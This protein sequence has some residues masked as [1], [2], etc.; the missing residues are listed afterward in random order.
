GAINGRGTAASPPGMECYDDGVLG[1][2]LRARVDRAAGAEM[3]GSHS[4]NV[5]RAETELCGAQPA[6]R[7]LG[8]LS[9]KPGSEAGSAGECVHGTKH[10][11]GRGIVGGDE[12]G[13]GLCPDESE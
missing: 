8:A 2:A 5:P 12:G 11:H 9:Q 13:W 4:S 7:L 3:A 6:R 10:G 1:P